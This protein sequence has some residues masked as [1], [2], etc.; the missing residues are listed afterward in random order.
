LNLAL[1]G[2]FLALGAFVGFLAGLLGVG[3][4]FT[5]VP[6]LLEVFHR[7]GVAVQHVVPM[8]IGTSAATIVFTALSS[9]RA[10]HAHGAI[11]WVAL[12]AL[13]PGLVLGS[14]A[15]AQIASALPAAIMTVLFGVFIW[16]AA[17]RMLV[18]KP[19][20]ATR[21]LPGKPAMFGVGTLIGVVSGMVGVGG[22]FLVV[23]FL[24]RSSVKLHTAVATSA[25]VG[26]AISVA[27]TVG[28]VYAGW[29][30]PGLPPWSVGYVYL[31][32]SPSWSP[33]RCSRRPARA[34][35]TSGPSPDCAS[36]SWAC[37]SCSAPTCGGRRCIFDHE[38]T[39]RGFPWRAVT[40]RSRNDR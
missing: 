26:V 5:I 20:A 36:R 12:R 29:H 6:V 21:T 24:T 15:G 17:F 35:R 11:H 31:P 1:L 2:I 38:N 19:D 4:G 8:A 23:P 16:F 34:W 14:V 40:G 25:A 30:A 3:G 10:H 9:A 33:A 18:H 13:A 37:C 27:A 39:A 7:Q 32:G 22:A 28:Y